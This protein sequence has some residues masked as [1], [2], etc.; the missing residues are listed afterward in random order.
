MIS[1]GCQ[2]CFS[3][4]EFDHPIQ[5]ALTMT[6][7]SDWK[8]DEHVRVSGNSPSARSSLFRRC[9]HQNKKMAQF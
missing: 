1:N 9:L 4:C 6:G 3:V 5:R 2:S 7:S 8:D